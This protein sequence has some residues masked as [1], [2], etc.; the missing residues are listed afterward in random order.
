MNLTKDA[1]PI[2]TFRGVLF[3]RP[4]T[5][6][7]WFLIESRNP[8]MSE[9]SDIVTTLPTSVMRCPSVPPVKPIPYLTAAS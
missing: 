1:E 7:L 5:S 2:W 3:S 6:T 8:S 9:A 4:Q